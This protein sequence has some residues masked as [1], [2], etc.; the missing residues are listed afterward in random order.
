MSWILKSG[1]VPK[2]FDFREL[3]IW[4]AKRFDSKHPLIEVKKIR[5]NLIPLTLNI[6]RRMIHLPTIDRVPKLLKEDSFLAAQG[7]SM[8]LVKKFLVQLLVG[9]SNI[10]EINTCMLYQLFK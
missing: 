9:S 10:N 3:V 8:G 6:F 2:A 4:C 1:C 5:R 7:G